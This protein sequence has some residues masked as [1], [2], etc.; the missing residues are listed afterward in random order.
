MEKQNNPFMDIFVRVYGIA[1]KSVERLIVNAMKN[2]P[3]N[4]KNL[5]LFVDYS[6]FDIS[7]GTE[8]TI[9]AEDIHG[10]KLHAINGK[11]IQVTQSWCKPFDQIP[12]G[13]KTVCEIEFDEQSANLIRSKL[14]TVES[15]STPERRFLL[16]TKNEI[17]TV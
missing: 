10:N 2:W 5:I 9:F 8:F 7:I 15:W 14:P 11:L 16:G 4:S 1:S 13:H 12:K 3:M 17:Q 6:D